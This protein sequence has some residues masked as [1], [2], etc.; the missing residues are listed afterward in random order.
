LTS[1]A[2]LYLDGVVRRDKY[3]STLSRRIDHFKDQQSSSLTR[4]ADNEPDGSLFDDYAVPEIHASALDSHALNRAITKSGCLI[5]RDFFNTKEVKDMRAYVDYSAS[6]H[7]NKDSAINRY[8]TKP[9][10]L[11]EV[12]KNTIE[13]IRVKQQKNSTYS[14]TAKLAGTFAQALG[15][16]Y[17]FFVART[18]LLTEK[19]LHLFTNKKLKKLL[20]EYFENDPCLSIYKWVIRKSEPPKNIIDFHQDGAFM[21]DDVSSVNCWIPL[22]NCGKGYSVH[23]LDVVPVPLK[24][25]FSKGSGVLD[26]T[27]AAH[28]VTE[29]YGE[30]AI[31]TPTFRKGDAFFFD[32]FLMHRSQ[33]LADSSE[34]R[35]AIE[36]W[37][38][39]SKYFPKNQI[40]LKW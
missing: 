2:L 32:E 29:R 3:L 6:L 14:N 35:Y 9:V 13:D 25:L 27:I 5:V 1:K 18:P 12:L 19:L 38:F 34:N 4:V 24:H 22:T 20:S 39:D 15:K 7:N 26:W 11:N 28:A 37:F 30:A 10:N 8:L 23:G 31:V 40:P 36:N 21:G 33:Y 16:N 17:S